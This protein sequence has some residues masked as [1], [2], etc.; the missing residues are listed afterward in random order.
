MTLA[1]T[2]GS[3]E[4]IR[5]KLKNG[6][7]Q[8]ILRMLGKALVLRHFL[9][10]DFKDYLTSRS[11]KSLVRTLIDSKLSQKMC[12][13]HIKKGEKGNINLQILHKPGLAPPLLGV[14]DGRDVIV[15][16]DQHF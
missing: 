15:L 10:K 6:E 11:I 13:L 1:K 2:S 16:P 14:E 5:T 12:L 3:G 7:T 8:I 9:W 4:W